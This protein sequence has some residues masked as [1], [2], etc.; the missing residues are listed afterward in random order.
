[1]NNIKIPSCQQLIITRLRHIILA[2]DS[3]KVPDH[4]VSRCVFPIPE[5]IA[6]N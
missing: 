1:M 4:L 6:E 2:A 3:T 5:W